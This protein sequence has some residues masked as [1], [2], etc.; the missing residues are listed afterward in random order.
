VIKDRLND[1]L[2]KSL[3]GGDQKRVGVLRLLN[4]AIHNKEIEKYA[5]S[6][7]EVLTDEEILQVLAGE[8]K[9]RRESIEIFLSGGRQDLAD[10]EKAELMVIQEYLPK[11]LSWEETE[12]AVADILKKSGLRDFGLA[13]KEVMKELKGKADAKII[14]ELVKKL[15]SL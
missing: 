13:M 3:K 7:S 1:D 10:K 11:Q 8:A 12:K 6:K 14:S 15:L 2:K 9:K 4:T 5:K